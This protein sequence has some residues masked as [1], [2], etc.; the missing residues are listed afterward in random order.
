[1]RLNLH[2]WREHPEAVR[3]VLVA[4]L[5]LLVAL[6]GV[7]LYQIDSDPWI[8]VAVVAAFA[9]VARWI[10]EHARVAQLLREVAQ[11]AWWLLKAAVVIA[12]ATWMF[13][14]IPTWQ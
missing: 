12:I 5:G 4:V 14:K 10:L 2:L 13:L 11:A 3:N 6:V 9:I 7:F 1:V 8:I